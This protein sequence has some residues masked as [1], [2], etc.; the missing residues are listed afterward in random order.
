MEIP[1]KQK[2]FIPEPERKT[3]PRQPKTL[4]ERNKIGKMYL[5]E[6]Y[7]TN[8]MKFKNKP[9]ILQ[10]FATL[11]IIKESFQKEKKKKLENWQKYREHQI[12]YANIMRS[13]VKKVGNWGN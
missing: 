6:I 9:S 11:D 3:I 10:R 1:L 8:E 13:V 2:S 7:E 12:K 4:G 5:N